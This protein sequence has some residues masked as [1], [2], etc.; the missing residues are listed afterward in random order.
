[1]VY[2]LIGL[3]IFCSSC[4]TTT[5]FNHT[6]KPISRIYHTVAPKDFATQHHTH[7]CTT[8]KIAKIK[9]EADGDIHIRINDSSKVGF[10]VAE[11]IPML[12][13]QGALPTKEGQLI[14]VC[15]IRRFDDKHKWY[16][17]H[18]VERIK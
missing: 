8:G 3:L 5:V 7:V 1:M 15:G 11:I 4:S 6:E 18:P 12:K 17:V 14:T 16:E 10:I 9:K 2:L 13:P